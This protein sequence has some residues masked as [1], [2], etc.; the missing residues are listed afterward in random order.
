MGFKELCVRVTSLLY[1]DW[2]HTSD[3]ILK[4][5]VFVS[6]KFCLRLDPDSGAPP[7]MLPDAVAQA[8]ERFLTLKAGLGAIAYHTSPEF[9][10]NFD[11]VKAARVHLKEVEAAA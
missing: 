4:Y 7:P 9:Q 2:A 1:I 8:T 3:Y 11:E 5:S 6:L 10:S